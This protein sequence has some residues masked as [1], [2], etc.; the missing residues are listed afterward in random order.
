MGLQ[1]DERGVKSGTRLIEILIETRAKG[2]T[3]LLNV[4]PKPN[5]ELPIEQ[6]A[7]L[8]EVALWH[9]V[10]AESIHSTRPWVVPREDWLTRK[11]DANTLYVFLT[12]RPDWP[13]GERREFLLRSVKARRWSTCP[14]WKPRHVFRNWQMD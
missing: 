1:A 8:R 11:K 3:L 6:E 12:R 7:R 9:A 10:N 14:R 5:G 4:G 2:G 13:R